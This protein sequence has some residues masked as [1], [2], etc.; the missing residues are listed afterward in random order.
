MLFLFH[1]LI[2]YC[3][4]MPS[5]EFF[6]FIRELGKICCPTAKDPND[7]PYALGNGNPQPSRLLKTGLGLVGGIVGYGIAIK[8]LPE[9]PAYT[10]G[11][12]YAGGRIFSDAFAVFRGKNQ[13]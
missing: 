8:L 1:A 5:V 3:G 10:I 9:N 6:N 13:I 2:G 11:A 12:A 7:S 4:T